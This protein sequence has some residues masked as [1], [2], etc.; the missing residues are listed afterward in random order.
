MEQPI[1]LCGLGR[2]GW[3][4][5][6]YLRAAGL[7]VV[8]VDTRCTLDDPR[9]AGARVVQGDCRRREVLEQAGV[10]RAAGVLV[11]TS[12]DLLNIS[13]AL[14]VRHLNPDVRVVVRM[15]NQNLIPRLGKAVRNIFS[16]STSSLVAPFLAVTALTG[17]ALGMFR[18][19]GVEDGRRQVADVTIGP[20]SALRGRAIAE[21]AGR[22]EAVV[23]AHFPGGRPPRFLTHVDGND[24][25]VAGDRLVVSGEPR[26]L[27]PLL[28][29]DLERHSRGPLR[30]W[31]RRQGRMAWR[32]LAEVDLPV[33]ICTAVLVAVIVVSTVVFTWTGAQRSVADSLF[34]AV[35][36]IATAGAL[37]LSDEPRGELKVYVSVLRII[38]A[39]LTATFTAIVTNYLLRAR[40]RG[41][42]E[43]RRIP[44]AG[45][46]VI[47]GLGNVGF[48]V[49]EELVGYG[50]RVVALEVAH[51][52]RFVTTARRL[53]VAVIHGD[54]TVREVLRQANAGTA[55]AVIAV[56]HNDLINLEIALLVRDLNPA[57]RVVLHLSDSHL[58]QMLREAASVHLAFSVAVL[59]APA[60]VAALFGDRVLNVFF[61]GDQ[62]LAVVDL[63]VQ[64]QDTAL[65]DHA[66][67]AVAVDYHLLPVAVL[68]PDGS[69]ERQLQTARL[70]A[71]SRLL[72]F[73]ALCDL[74][75]FVRRQ[76]V[77]ANC[78]VDVT[79]FPL[80]ARDWVLVMLRTRQG[81]NAEAA[82]R[83]LARLP[84]R[85]GSNLTRGQAEDLLALMARE[86]V[87][88]Q[89]CQPAAPSG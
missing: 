63:L 50:E 25:L 39:A 73:I 53:G 75:R 3:R 43:V 27:A 55:R 10:T 81:L 15:F 68:R 6:E 83:A 9:L 30:S 57:Q 38:G 7:P 78:A 37:P 44:D 60:F 84:V 13:T 36:L 12:D 69:V 17:Q 46:V 11:L 54:A 8:V 66:V 1:I 76:P 23:L 65:L 5:L 52:N 80:P 61:V 4:V 47:C 88:G 86:K 19:E 42:L 45:H 49:L 48:R 89:L 21:V 34:R 85:L 35:G 32:A 62:L 64:P 40:L 56:T 51:D 14:M 67:R 82:E 29:D 79:G 58:A 22:H 70:A 18:I 16:L 24:R 20:A 2:V 87:S 74:E 26:A 77:P 31:T 28:G 59:A 33:K 72:A 41:A 71:G